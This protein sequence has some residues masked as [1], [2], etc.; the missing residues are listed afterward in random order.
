MKY[1]IIDTETTGGSPRSSKIIE[2]AICIHDGYGLQQQYETLIDPERPIPPDITGI[3]RINNEMV[4]GAPKFFEVAKEVLEL[5]QDAIIV[6]HNSRFDYAMLREEYRSLGYNFERRQLCTVNLSRKLI[7]GMDSYSLG[8]LCRQLGISING[9]HRAMGDCYAT[10]LLFERILDTYRTEYK[11]EHLQ[12]E[13]LSAVFPEHFPRER[14]AALPEEPGVY[15]FRNSAGEII[16]VGMSKNIR[17][18]VASH[19]S[20]DLKSQKSLRMKQEVCEVDFETTGN[21]LTASL[22]EDQEIKRLQPKYNRASRKASFN[23]GIFWKEDAAGYQRL[24][25]AQ[26]NGTPPVCAF[27]TGTKAKKMVERLAEEHQL[28]HRMAGL[29][30]ARGPCFRYHVKLCLGA[31][32]GEETPQEH[33]ERVQKALGRFQFKWESFLIIGKG[34]MGSEMTA[35][36]VERNAYRGWGFFDPDLTGERPEEIL[37]CIKPSGDNPD[38]RK[39]LRKAL[40]KKEYR[41]IPL[42]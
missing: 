12:D 28:C 35:V 1:A 20:A 29:D 40:R 26:V 32:L 37:F 21:E 14:V 30:H 2:I 3:T 27:S 4:K 39:L 25:V 24:Q 23:W 17:K 15:F 13:F 10:T 38:V 34:R 7:P 18:R 11:E 6:A 19:F 42:S 5:T 33:N 9:R 41:V 36:H 16:Y 22:L 31:C 8:K